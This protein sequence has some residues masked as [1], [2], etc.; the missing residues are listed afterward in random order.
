MPT[1]TETR[2]RVAFDQRLDLVAGLL[3]PRLLRREPELAE[4]ALV[5]TGATLL[6]GD[7]IDVELSVGAG[8]TLRVRDTSAT[9]AY[10]GR[11]HSASVH[12]RVRVGA[13]ALL[14]WDAQPLVL[15]TGAEVERTLDVEV[16]EGGVLLLRDTLALGRAAE[17]GGVLRCRTNATYDGRPAL[18][19]TL[20]LDAR[21]HD[22][23]V[24]GPHRVVDSAL[25]VGTRPEAAAGTV[26]DLAEP[27]RLV[28]WLGAATHASAVATV[29]G[30]WKSEGEA[31]LRCS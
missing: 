18:V 3:A 5:A 9:V 24:L 22:V 30:H 15:A 10:H 7:R 6:G 2:L 4:V 12:A 25:A 1:R 13:G 17:D 23:G 16:A 26:F 14:V 20:T 19:E 28:R 31:S 11:G 29:W 21:R 8:R 27:G